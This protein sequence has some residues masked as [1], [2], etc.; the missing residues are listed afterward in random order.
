MAGPNSL[1]NLKELLDPIYN[2]FDGL[3]ITLHDSIGSPEEQY[4]ESIKGKGKIIHLPYSRRHNF[5][6]N[7]YLYCG[8]LKNGDWVVQCDDL[9]R[10]NPIFLTTYIKNLISS[11]YNCFYY[12]G[13]VFV[14]QYHESLEFIGSPHE[15]LRRNDGRMIASDIKSVFPIENDVRYNVRPFKRSDPY[16]WVGHYFKY[17][18]F[19]WGSNQ[20]LLGAE[21]RGDPGQVFAQ[22]EV[23]RNNFIDYL[24][25]L[26]VEPTPDGVKDYWTKSPIDD[27]MRQ[28]INSEKILNDAY[29]YFILKDL[30]VRDEH[31]WVTLK[32]I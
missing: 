12:Y 29:R 24:V 10:I 5:S 9:E 22:R 17:Y 15:G 6:R 28:F 30:S 19:P 4:L 13:K 16:H 23:I 1:E 2:F 18:L 25:S 32:N 31:D 3:I 8:P 27:R 11:S 20:C 26:G 7:A 21:H 14:Y